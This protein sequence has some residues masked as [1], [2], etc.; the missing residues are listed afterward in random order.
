MRSTHLQDDHIARDA[1][2]RLRLAA[3]GKGGARER[4]ATLATV[5]GDIPNAVVVEEER[6]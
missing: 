4:Q 1:F 2:Q 6:I 3:R 5:K